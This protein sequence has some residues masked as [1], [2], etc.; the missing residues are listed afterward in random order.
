MPRKGRGPHLWLHPE[1]RDAA[2]RITHT[3]IGTSRT[4]DVARAR[5]ALNTTL[6][7]LNVRFSST[8]TANT[9]PVPDAPRVIPLKS[10]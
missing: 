7:E 6:Q 9:K 2:G 3:T 8:S 5:R 4:V 1:R 10:R